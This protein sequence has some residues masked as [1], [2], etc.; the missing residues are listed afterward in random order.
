MHIYTH[1]ISDPRHTECSNLT[2][3][4]WPLYIY[5][6]MKTFLWQLIHLGTED[7]LL[8]FAIRLETTT[9]TFES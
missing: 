1:I 2:E 4:R 3:V 7:R 6:I 5:V 9:E 8:T